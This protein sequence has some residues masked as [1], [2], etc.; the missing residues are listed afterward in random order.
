MAFEKKSLGD[1][2]TLK[3]R[4]PNNKVSRKAVDKDAQG[5]GERGSV[6]GG[7]RR[8]LKQ[9]QPAADVHETSTGPRRDFK[10]TAASNR[11]SQGEPTASSKE[12]GGVE[13][14]AAM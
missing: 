5:R 6:R 8:M 9:E 12:T 10:G 7:W 3:R 4:N 13:V 11:L 2:R 14:E 1:P